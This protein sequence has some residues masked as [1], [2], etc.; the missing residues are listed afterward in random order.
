M[1]VPPVALPALTSALLVAV[2]HGFAAEAQTFQA[3]VRQDN[4]HRLTRP[5]GKVRRSAAL[6]KP[7]A[8]LVDTQAFM[9]HLDAGPGKAKGLS[10][11][12]ADMQ[13]AAVRGGFLAE[14]LHPEAAAF[15]AP[16]WDLPRAAS[17]QPAA[18]VDYAAIEKAYA[19]SVPPLVVSPRSTGQPSGVPIFAAV[20]QQMAG[21]DNMP[22][23]P[24][25]DVDNCR[26][27]TVIPTNQCLAERNSMIYGRSSMRRSLH[28]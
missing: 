27:G 28:R 16:E 13:A 18:V 19:E 15:K 11:S 5:D 8:S 17:P 10:A 1:K 20:L 12:A 26:C 14:Q 22:S 21:A 2:F 25:L 7:L 4:V 6:P 3:E 23:G 24:Q 9:L